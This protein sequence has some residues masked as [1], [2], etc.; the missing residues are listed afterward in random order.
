MLVSGWRSW[1]R[2]AA[3]QRCP[4]SW[5]SHD[6]KN[7]PPST[8]TTTTKKLP[9]LP[10]SRAIVLDAEFPAEKKGGV[11]RAAARCCYTGH[12]CPRKQ[13]NAVLVVGSLSEYHCW[14]NTEPIAMLWRIG[15]IRSL[16]SCRVRY[17]LEWLSAVSSSTFPIQTSIPL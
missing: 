2:R 9:D 15:S 7:A 17:S 8:T 14:E 12:E 11:M 13:V 6:H 10:R 1:M 16:L 3:V 4:L 5:R